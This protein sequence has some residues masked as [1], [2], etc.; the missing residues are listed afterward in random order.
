MEEE[1]IIMKENIQTVLLNV[2]I[3]AFQTDM[4]W[5]KPDQDMMLHSTITQEI[6]VK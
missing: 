2:E 3:L 4:N 1:E 6:Q 5:I